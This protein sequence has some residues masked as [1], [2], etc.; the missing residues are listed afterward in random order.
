MAAHVDQRDLLE[1]TL[2]RRLDTLC[3]VIRRTPF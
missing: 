3:G 2:Y 1:D